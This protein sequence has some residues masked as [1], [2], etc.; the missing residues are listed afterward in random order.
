MREGEAWGGRPGERHLQE[1]AEPVGSGGPTRVRAGR[2]ALQVVRELQLEDGR[3]ARSVRVDDGAGG[4][5]GHR[6]VIVALRLLQRRGHGRG[7]G[8]VRG[9]RRVVEEGLRIGGRGQVASGGHGHYW[10]LRGVGAAVDIRAPS[11]TLALRAGRRHRR[12]CVTTT[13]PRN[14]VTATVTLTTSCWEVCECT[15]THTDT[16]APRSKDGRYIGHT[17]AAQQL[18]RIYQFAVPVSLARSR[19]AN[20][21]SSIWHRSLSQ[22]FHLFGLLCIYSRAEANTLEGSEQL[23]GGW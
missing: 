8:L 5:R 13:T 19:L 20:C 9:R 14:G 12:G 11:Y 23:Q 10:W 22:S 4:Q 17:R 18:R 16:H 6:H 21:P 1:V 3:R 7:R 2:Q 15:E